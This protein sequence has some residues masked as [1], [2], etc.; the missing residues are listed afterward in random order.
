[1]E[2][3]ETM[4]AMETMEIKLKKLKE[5]YHSLRPHLEALPEASPEAVAQYTA[6]GGT[7]LTLAALR[8]EEEMVQVL[9]ASGAKDVPDRLGITAVYEARLGKD[10]PTG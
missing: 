3:I 9:L 7:E 6:L 8:G 1:M 10:D 5:L 2:T 4:E